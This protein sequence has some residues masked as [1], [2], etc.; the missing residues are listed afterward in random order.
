MWHETPP[1]K[2]DLTNMT[3]RLVG[4]HYRDERVSTMEDYVKEPDYS[5]SE[6]NEVRPGF[7]KY[8]RRVRGQP[9][10]IDR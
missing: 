6:T 10:R 5:D 4:G 2:E 1:N 3:K 8:R 7:V 9:S